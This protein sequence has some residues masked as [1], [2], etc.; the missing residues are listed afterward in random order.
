MGLLRSSL[1][2]DL[3]GVLYSPVREIVL[4]VEGAQLVVDLRGIVEDPET[5]E[6]AYAG[7]AQTE[8][9]D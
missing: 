3:D 5:E 2:G 9:T 6:E 4:T 1:E 8:R 7:K